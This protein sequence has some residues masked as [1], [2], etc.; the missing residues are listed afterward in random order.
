MNTKNPYL[1]PEPDP[2][3]DLDLDLKEEL[4]MAPLGPLRECL[5]PAVLYT[6]NFL[7]I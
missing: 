4:P 7:S 5:Y 1:D 3:L 2:D 6:S